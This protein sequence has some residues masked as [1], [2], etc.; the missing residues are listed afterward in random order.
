MFFTNALLCLK[1][2]GLQARVETEWFA[3]CGRRFL[4]PTIDLIRPKILISLGQLAYKAISALHGLRPFRFRE[5]VEYQTGFA[6]QGGIRYFPT[7]HCGAR[8]LHT[9]RPLEQQINDWGKIA[10]AVGKG[11]KLSL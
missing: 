6:L 3:N 11:G 9:H 1:K 7:Y 5:A 4:K 8:I 10:V 2:G